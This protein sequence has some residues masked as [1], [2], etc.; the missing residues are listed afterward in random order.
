MFTDV[1]IVGRLTRDPELR[2]TGNGTAVTNFSLAVNR[3]F[4][5]D[6]V[7]FFDVTAW[8]QL[9]ELV[10]A[11][12]TKGDLVLVQGNLRQDRFKGQN[13]EN[14]TKVYVVANR[15][16]FLPSKSDGENSSDSTSSVDSDDDI[17]F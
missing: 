4:K 17:P 8:K 7:D 6:E 14:R 5:N 10:A 12:K 16:V 11:H 13:D 15:V 9:A 1:T 3:D 2:Q